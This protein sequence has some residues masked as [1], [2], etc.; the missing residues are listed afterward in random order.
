M[1]TNDSKR[2]LRIAGVSLI[3]LMLFWDALKSNLSFSKSESAGLHFAVGKC[4]ASN[5]CCCYPLRAST[6]Y[7]HE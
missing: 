4:E 2:S 3:T 7:T 1:N 6:I 5:R